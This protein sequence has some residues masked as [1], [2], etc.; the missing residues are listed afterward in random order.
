VSAPASSPAGIA[1]ETQPPV[2]APIPSATGGESCPLCGAPLHPEQEWCL[3][4]GAAAR[5]RLAASPNWKAPLVTAVIVVVLS[6]GVLAAALVKLAGGSASQSPATTRT[7]TTAAALAPA[8]TP[9]TAG[10]TTQT[11]TGITTPGAATTTTSTSTTT[12]PGT[13]VSTV[14]SSTGAGTGTGTGALTPAKRRSILEAI[15]KHSGI[16]VERL[17][18]LGLLPKK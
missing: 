6:L 15:R 2:R 17:R 13:G 11:T 9:T 10:T 14:P 5:T 16:S 1:G 7:I 18:K 12:T 4:C 8:T 3:N